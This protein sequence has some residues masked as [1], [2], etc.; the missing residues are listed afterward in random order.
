MAELARHWPLLA[1]A[2]SAAML[3]AA[4]AFERLGGYAPCEL[5]LRQREVYWIALAVAAGA[6]VFQLVQKRASRA[7]DALLAG[8]FL[9]G[10]AVAAYH[11]GIEWTWWPGP[12]TCSAAAGPPP[13]PTG[14]LTQPLN[15]VLCDEAAWR[16]AGLSMAGW[17][18][19]VSGA[20]V[21]ASLAASL[22]GR[23]DDAKA[24]S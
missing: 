8:V 4:H 18:A 22:T 11:A 19:L 12:E 6:G 5:C 14:D 9:L 20:L 1:G 7:L 3:A 17:N 23:D 15:P 21:A 13:P 2:A 10:A 16:L 24:A